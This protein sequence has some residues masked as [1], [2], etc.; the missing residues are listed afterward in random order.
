M[1]KAIEKVVITA[2]MIDE[3]ASIREQ[4]ASLSKREADLKKTLRADCDGVDTVYRGAHYVLKT[5]F[6]T[7]E[8]LDTTKARDVLGEEWCSANTKTVI[9][10]NIDSTE[11]LQ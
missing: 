9:A 11:V 8:R 3:I 1:A 5:K 10:M 2:E 7:Q 4:I 6:V